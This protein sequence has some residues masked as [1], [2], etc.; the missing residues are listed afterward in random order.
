M[1]QQT[2]IALTRFERENGVPRTAS[3]SR[4]NRL[5]A[6]QTA[7]AGSSMQRTHVARIAKTPKAQTAGVGSSTPTK[8][9][10]GTTPMTPSATVMPPAS[11]GGSTSIGK[12]TTGQ[13]TTTTTVPPATGTTTGR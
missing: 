7:G 10:T 1:D 6:N 11:A 8:Q 9:S 4:V 5:M 3:L 13:S 2:R 12:P